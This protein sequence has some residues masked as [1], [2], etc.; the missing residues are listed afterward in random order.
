MKIC[1]QCILPETYPGITFDKNGVCNYCNNYS[2]QNQADDPSQQFLTEAELIAALQKHKKSESPYDV[3]VPASGGVDISFTLIKI[4]E[5]FKLTPLVF[6][7]DHG[8]EADVALDTVR[9]LC[10]E[11][12]VDLL[13]WQHDLRFMKKLWKFTLEAD[14]LAAK[15]CFLCANVLYWYAIQLADKFGISLVI[16]GYSKGQIA[17]NKAAGR[18]LLMEM[19]RKMLKTDPQPM[20]S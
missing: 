3:L 17:L 15:T 19:I 9:K 1:N 20:T 13:V 4:V 2:L 18:E 6:H 11:L 14:T 12:D 16:N 10:Q 7:N 5:D 8:Y